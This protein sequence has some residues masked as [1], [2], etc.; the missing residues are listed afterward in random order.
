MQKGKTRS[1]SLF[2][3]EILGWRSET[4]HYNNARPGL[5]IE[6]SSRSAPPYLAYDGISKF[7]SITSGSNYITNG[8]IQIMIIQ[9]D[10]LFIDHFHFIKQSILP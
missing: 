3:R 5:A 7:Y 8:S 4:P 2:L 6:N 10:A 9:F 1:F